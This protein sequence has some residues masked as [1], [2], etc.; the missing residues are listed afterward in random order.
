MG[1]R[2]RLEELLVDVTPAPVLAG[3][4]ADDDRML[5]LMKVSGRVLAD[6]VVAAADMATRHAQP[7]VDPV[8]VFRE[9]FLASAQLHFNQADPERGAAELARALV[10]A[11]MSAPTH[12]LAGRILVEI[13][14]PD[15]ARKH[16]ET[17]RGLDPGRWQVIERELARLDAP[18]LRW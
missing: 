10:R 11:P 2:R 18:P 17:A 1:V 14:G 13:E 12:E 3:L 5:R 8:H 16:Y 9:A 6:R 15:P 4:E 7:E